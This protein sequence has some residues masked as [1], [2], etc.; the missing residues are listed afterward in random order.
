MILYAWS[1]RL[2]ADIQWAAGSPSPRE[3]FSGLLYLH[4]FPLSVCRP[5][6]VVVGGAKVADK[7]GVLGSLIPKADVVL[8]GGR[9]TFTFLS[10]LHLPS[11]FFTFLHLPDRWEV[12]WP[13]PSSRP[14]ASAWA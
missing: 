3:L 7:I 11:P 5:L 8:V 10:A 6:A 12:A 2:N 4:P 9:M 1:W 14:R 13:S